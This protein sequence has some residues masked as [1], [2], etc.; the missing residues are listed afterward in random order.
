MKKTR[1]SKSGTAVQV[2]VGPPTASPSTSQIETFT[3][4][5][6]GSARSRETTPQPQLQSPVTFVTTPPA[7]TTRPTVKNHTA[8]PL[9]SLL[10]PSTP[11]NNSRPPFIFSSTPNSDF[12]ASP[13]PE[14]PNLATPYDVAAE[15]A[16]PHALFSANFQNALK[17]GPEIAQEATRALEKMQIGVKDAELGKFL[18]DAKALQRF[19]GTDTRKIAVLGDSGEG[20]S[21]LINSL[22]HFPGVA[23]TSDIG[24]AC[25]SVVTEYRQKKADHAALITIEVEYLSTFEIRDLIE[26]LLWSYRQLFLPSV[27]SEETSEQDYNRF[28]RESEQAWSALHAAFKHKRQFTQT[29]AQDMSDGALE[30]ITEQLVQWAVEIEWPTSG[31]DGFWTSTAETAD[32]CVEKTKLFMQDRF[33]PFTKII[34]VYL[35]SSV[36]KTGVVLAD[37]PGLQDTNLARVRATQDYLIKCDTI[38]IVAKISRAIT[39]QSLKS[40]LFYVLSRHMPMEWEQSGTQ[41]LNVSVVCTKSEEINLRN[42]RLEFCGPNKSISLETMAQ[43]DEEIDAAKASGDRIRK[44][45]A[46]KQ[47]ELLLIEARN[48]HVRQNLQSVYSSEMEGR[49]LEVFCVSNKWYEKYCPKGNTKFVEASG[50]PDLRRFCHTVTADAQFNEAKH[51]LKSRLSALLITLDLWADSSL[52][53]QEVEQPDDSILAKVKGIMDEIPSL[54]TTFKVDFTTCFREQI[55]LFFGRRDSHWDQA[56]SKEGRVWTSWHWS[57]YNAWCL[58]N[59]DHETMKRGHE[60]WNAK[61]IWKM[62]MELEGQWD[63]VEEEVYD[64]FNELLEAMKNRLNSLKSSLRDSLPCLLA[65]PVVQSIDVQVESLDYRMSREQRKFHSE[66][67]AIRRYATE[68]NYNSYILQDMIPVYRSAAS[69]QG[70]GKAARQISIVQGHI[71]QGVIFPKMGIAMSENMDQL[72]HATSQRLEGMLSGILAIVSSDLDIVFQRSRA[73]RDE[74]RDSKIRDFTSQIK[75]LREKHKLL[76]QN[77]EGI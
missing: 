45:T 68:T 35:D 5:A 60:N 56:A 4:S 10:S 65:D 66:V 41:R 21:S 3:F 37:L 33:W 34:R 32:E 8:A 7:Q 57:Q 39:D 73:T 9:F 38:M 36:L 76:L 70:D 47:Q 52:R 6:P 12:T 50:V 46:K 20:K 63:L 15:A 1:N 22:L 42:A 58:N 54:V 77:V 71:E 43:L 62:R 55:M 30:R 17:Q 64:V 29:F 51:F 40:S 19:Q 28:M 74:T 48:E 61:I 59:G 26:E 53:K 72:I 18:V 11:N 13:T 23:Q 27:E 16:L 67:R 25:T 44:K 24:S 75:S 2:G 31:R 49:M 69:Q 14:P